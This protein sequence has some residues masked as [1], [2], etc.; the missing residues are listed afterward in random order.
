MPEEYAHGHFAGSVNVPIDTLPSAVSRLRPGQ[1]ITTCSLGGRA[2]PRRR[3]ASASRQ[4][5]AN[6]ALA[7]ETVRFARAYSVEDLL[8]ITR[9]GRPSIL[10]PFKQQLHDRWNDGCLH[11]FTA[12]LQRD[13]AA[14]VNG[15]T[16]PH[17][18]GA[19]EDNVNRIK[20][21]QTTD[22]WSRR[23]RPTSQANPA[24]SLNMA[25]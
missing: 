21:D 20:D 12:G 14:V 19:V 18:S 4:L 9:D 24:G 1:I 10:D 11:S 6:L 16:L 2:R 13:H 5:C 15:L 23:L 25:T 22:V 8:A 7:P 17:S 3:V